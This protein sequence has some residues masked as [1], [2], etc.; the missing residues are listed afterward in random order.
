MKMQLLSGITILS[1]AG[2]TAMA[3]KNS[4]NRVTPSNDTF[5]RK[6]AEGGLAEVELGKLA[7]TH[8]SSDAVKNF[9]MR[10]V[11]DH[12]RI[13]AQLNS[14]AAQENVALPTKLDS[15]DQAALDRLSM[16]N[17]PQFDRVYMANM[18]RDHRT[19]IAEFQREANDGT[20][21]AMKQFASS[22][23]PTLEDHLRQAEDTRKQVK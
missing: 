19:D 7:Q 12:T 3:Q 18:V 17:G 20:D 21:P 4:A 6:A 22:N 15:K 16:L 8:A 10:M 13:N 9:G 5:M 1:L 11:N 2:F 14:I 23:L